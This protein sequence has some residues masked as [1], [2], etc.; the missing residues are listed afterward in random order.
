MF[1]SKGINTKWNPDS[2]RIW[3]RVPDSIYFKNNR[4]IKRTST[5]LQS[6]LFDG[7]KYQA[8]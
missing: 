5:T 4:Y 7:K 8:F 6:A 3:R 2:S 1:F